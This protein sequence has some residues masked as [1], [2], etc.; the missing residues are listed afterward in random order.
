MYPESTLAK[1]NSSFI[2]Q[3]ASPYDFYDFVP[4]WAHLEYDDQEVCPSDSQISDETDEK[5]PRLRRGVPTV[6]GRLEKL[7]SVRKSPNDRQTTRTKGAT[8][9]K[10]KQFKKTN[11]WLSL[12]FRMQLCNNEISSDLKYRC[13]RTR[14]DIFRR[15]IHAKTIGDDITN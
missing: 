8:R 3:F 2:L 13:G 12:K 1:I 4:Q 5:D 9:R 7:I 14:I 10:I 6:Y 11:L 15:I